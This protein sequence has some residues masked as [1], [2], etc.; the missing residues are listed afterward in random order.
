MKK[1]LKIL[2]K[3][4]K[5][6]QCQGAA[7][8][9]EPAINWC[10]ATPDLPALPPSGSFRSAC[11]FE[12]LSG[13]VPAQFAPPGGQYLCKVC[14]YTEVLVVLSLSNA[15]ACYRQHVIPRCCLAAALAGDPLLL[16]DKLLK[17]MPPIENDNYGSALG[18]TSPLFGRRT[19]RYTDNVKRS[20]A[21]DKWMATIFYYFLIFHGP[22]IKEG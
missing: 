14:S 20:K 13:P 21:E 17:G 9:S 4:E 2:R 22:N 18:G 15:L 1:I 11:P 8:G 5:R 16:W 3:I 7:K 6:S 10:V 19:T 12:S